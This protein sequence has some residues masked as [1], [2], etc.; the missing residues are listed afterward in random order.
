MKRISSVFIFIILLVF[1]SVTFAESQYNIPLG[2]GEELLLERELQD[3]SIEVFLEINGE[4]YR[5]LFKKNQIE[6][7]ITGNGAYKLVSDE[8]VP[9]RG[10]GLMTSIGP[11]D[12]DAE[13]RVRRYIDKHRLSSA[14]LPESIDYSYSPHLPNVGDQGYNNSCVGWAT[15]YYLRTYQQ[16]KDLGWNVKD[17]YGFNNPERVFSPSFIYNQIYLGEDQGAYYNDAYRL[18]QNQGAASLE[19][20]PVIEGDYR[21]QPSRE[22]IKKA[23]PHRIK[24]F[25]SMNVENHS[26]REKRQMLKEYLR[27]GELPVIGMFTGYEFSF[28]HYY[29]DEYFVT[30]EEYLG[31]VGGHALVIVGY[32]DNIITPEGVGAFKIINSW[33]EHWGDAG[34]AYVTYEALD[35][36]IYTMGYSID[37]ENNERP[38]GEVEDIVTEQISN[39]SIKYTW[40]N[41][42]NAKGYRIYDEDHNIIQKIS[43]VNEYVE[44]IENI[45]S[46]KI[47]TRYIQA[48]NDIYQGELTEIKINIEDEK[49]EETDK[50]NNKIEYNRKTSKIIESKDNESVDKIWNIKFNK[51]IKDGEYLKENI[52]VVDENN[53]TEDIDISFENNLDLLKIIPVDNY[54]PGKIYTIVI[55]NVQ[56]I[57]GGVLK[58]NTIMDF[59]V[60]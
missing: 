58:Q 43:G 2:K 12:K 53:Y 20:F 36:H 19:E 5:K 42:F 22:I 51:N 15:G 13:E 3:G 30:T 56:D 11:E 26:S 29:N 31:K 9:Q 10:K 25:V 52:F 21:T 38:L 47:I 45:N 32:D 46:P 6:G 24:D 8:I 50:E 40:E 48:F 18:L 35:E 55:K 60:R 16:S 23:Y 59:N 34:Y 28:P 33:G 54:E 37:L 14:R 44:N 17:Y 27:I 4:H 39:N 57:E 1:G 41:D 49:N 7:H